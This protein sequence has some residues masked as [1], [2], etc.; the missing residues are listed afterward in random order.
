MN[1]LAVVAQ[2]PKP[3]VLQVS[4]LVSRARIRAAGKIQRSADLEIGDTARWETCGTTSQAPQVVVMS[5]T[6]ASKAGL[7]LPTAASAKPKCR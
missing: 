3:A 1:L 5:A 6:E 4:K 7:S 2:A